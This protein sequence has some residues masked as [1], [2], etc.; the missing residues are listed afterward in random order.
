MNKVYYLLFAFIAIGVSSAQADSFTISTVGSSYSPASL[1]VNVGDEITIMA[2]GTHPLVQVTEATWNAN[3]ATPM[4]GGFGPVTSAHTFTATVPGVIYY[5]CQNHVSGGMKGMITVSAVTGI[6][7]ATAI[8]SLKIY[9][10]IVSDGVFNVSSEGDILEGA[11]LELFSAT[12]QLVR[13]FNIDAE[14]AAFTANVA[15]GTYTAVIRVNDKAL[16]RERMIF[17]AE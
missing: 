4:G 5:V 8:T 12:G 3:M 11:T 13:S 6:E 1:S 16:L 15:T 14:K 17:M 9:P 10:T 2:S 7:D